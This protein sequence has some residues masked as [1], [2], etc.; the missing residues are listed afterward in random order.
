M[1][2]LMEPPATTMTP[3]LRAA[4]LALAL[5]LALV[6]L[7]PQA[8][9][10][11]LQGL[12]PAETVLAL[13]LR[14]LEDASALLDA[15]VDPWVELGVGE[16]LT[17][18]L[19][20]IDPAAL[21]GG[22]PL[23]ADAL[24]AEAALPAELDGIEAMDL[25]GREAWLGVSVSPFNPLPALTLLARVDGETG[26][27]FAALLAREVR[28]GALE[29]GEG[30]IRFVQVDGGALPLAAALDGDLLALS[31]NPDVLRGVLRLRQ[32]SAEPSFGRAPGAAATLG[33][34]GD[35]EF[36]GFLDLGPLARS[37]APLAG[38]L[39]FDASVARLVG[40]LETLGPVAGV[41]RL[42]ADGTATTTLRRLEPAGGDAA[43]VR[44][45]S[46]ASPAPR[47]LLAWVPEGALAVTVTGL[48]LGAWWAYLGDVAGG[49]RE[50]GVPD[51]N[52][53]VADVL[54]V[55]LSR[56]LFGWTAPG[57][58]IIQTGAGE[59]A[60]IAAAVDDLLGESVVGL[61][62]R[63][64]AA[65]EAGL[66]RLL[67]ELTRRVSLFAD[68]FAAPGATAQVTV[69]EREVAGVTLRA[70]A[71][72]PG[73]TLTTA[74]ADGVAW[75]GTTEAGLEDVL[76][77]GAA[78][79]GPPAAFAASLQDVPDGV[80]GFSLS[81]DRAS[82]AATG[83]SLAQQVQLLAGFAGGGLDFDAIDRATAAVEAYIDR[84]APR[85]GGTVS[86]SEAGA[87]GLL[88]GEER[89]TIDLR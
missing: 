37:L 80:D 69:Q 22:V 58:V 24:E 57:L 38:G 43:L 79:D 29:L 32:G 63:D 70:Y 9:A 30:A 7:M 47:E 11:D 51:L 52:R 59:L 75:I 72:L 65:A 61:R 39:G 66:G 60:P 83:A 78:G 86:W 73:L 14:G 5:I 62:T 34:L 36:V 85:F 23:D 25:L 87:D 77:A 31:S 3:R 41:T 46:T 2:D 4:P 40:L 44:L 84:I 49:L 21:L 88:R 1:M 64:A 16:A 81:D 54:G 71:V 42:S 35:G 89:V 33:A 27:R 68:P 17:A 55:D 53:T 67:D 10:Q 76:R 18:A 15:F 12:L 45:L 82:L 56:D 8:R 13:G 74:V 6:A 28:E 50:L 20:G 48:D 19:G 26:A